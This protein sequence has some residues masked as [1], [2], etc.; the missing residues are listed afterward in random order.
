VQILYI[1]C[2]QFRLA[3][4][5]FSLSVV[6]SIL[7]RLAI[8]AGYHRDPIHYPSMTLFEG[9]LRRRTW[10]ILVHCDLAFA[11]TCGLPRILND[12]QINIRLPSNYLDEDLDPNM[13][14]LP[15][16]RP[17]TEQTWIG[18]LNYKNS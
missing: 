1:A 18:Y 4:A 16:P 17:D 12:R 5:D 3:N 10:A 6:F 13:V 15:S 2:E 14:E 7:V 9:E 11:V 8:R